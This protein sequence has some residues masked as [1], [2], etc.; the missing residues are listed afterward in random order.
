MSE[1][2]DDATNEA[3][4]A[5]RDKN[6]EEAAE[7]RQPFIVGSHR[8]LLVFLHVNVHDGDRV[9]SGGVGRRHAESTGGER[10]ATVAR[11]L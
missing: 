5:A 10:A 9:W 4:P 3:R 2:A 1:N 11:T 8:D 6:V 7:H